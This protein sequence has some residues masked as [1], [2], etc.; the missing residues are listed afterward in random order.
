MKDSSLPTYMA[1]V[2]EPKAEPNTIERVPTITVKRRHNDSSQD[3]LKQLTGG[4]FGAGSRCIAHLTF[5]LE[6]MPLMDKD[7]SSQ[8]CHRKT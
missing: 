3:D 5:E 1:K 4:R 8:P 6:L 7:R 2:V